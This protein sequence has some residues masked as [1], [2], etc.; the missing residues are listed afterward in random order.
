VVSLTA[1]VGNDRGGVKAAIQ[2][3]DF[4]RL[5]DS[6]LSVGATSLKYCW[7]FILFLFL[8]CLSCRRSYYC[9]YC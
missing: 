9:A 6:L 8:Y 2:V 5:K 3:G 7:L 1:V 4:P